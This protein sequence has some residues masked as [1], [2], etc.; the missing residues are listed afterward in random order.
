MKLVQ[1]WINAKFAEEYLVDFIPRKGEEVSVNNR[2]YRVDGVVH[3]LG[4]ENDTATLNRPHIR[5]YLEFIQ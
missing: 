2:L 4:R 5:L 1:L 3:Y